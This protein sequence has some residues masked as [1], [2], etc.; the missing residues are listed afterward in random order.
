MLEELHCCHS[1]D[2]V[3]VRDV[4]HQEMKTLSRAIEW[5]PRS[6]QRSTLLQKV[7]AMSS[8]IV[9]HDRGPPAPF[10]VTS[11][12]AFTVTVSGTKDESSTAF[13]ENSDKTQTIKQEALEKDQ[14]QMESTGT[15][16][17]APS[18]LDSRF[19]ERAKT[20]ATTPTTARTDVS[21]SFSK[22][23]Q[24]TTPVT[25]HVP[26]RK[27]AEPTPAQ[28]LIPSTA[29]STAAPASAPPVVKRSRGRPPGSGRAAVLAAAAASAAAAA[30]AARA[31]P[32]GPQGAP[33]RDTS[34]L[35]GRRSLQLP[36]PS[37]NKTISTQVIG[38]QAA[39]EGKVTIEVDNEVTAGRLTIQ[40]LRC[41][42]SGQTVWETILTCKALSLVA[43]S[44]FIC[45]NCEDKTLGVYSPSGRRLLPSLVLPS[46]GSSIKIKGYHIM[47]ISTCG[48]LFVWDVRKQQAVVNKV[49]LETIIEPGISI[50]KSLLTDQGVPVIG[51]SN[52]KSFMYSNPMCCWLLIDHK[53]DILR[54]TSDHQPCQPAQTPSHSGGP[55]SHVQ[56]AQQR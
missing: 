48:K 7:S 51:L 46:V 33:E 20:P 38:K 9:F 12:S 22:E 6:G 26:R 47:A 54:L 3:V 34:R 49:S 52:G 19:T 56:G 1:D 32:P 30:A 13:K 8:S 45:V 39:G 4:A 28:G 41:I 31:T 14:E 15:D 2:G 25:V 11:N 37:A 55:L 42:K 36:T 23:M 27:E 29:A 53:E 17:K 10:T 24:F 21:S 16:K 18:A 44:N 50:S 35:T 5:L 43:N 40:K